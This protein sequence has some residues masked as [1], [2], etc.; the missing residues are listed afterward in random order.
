MRRPV[1][2]NAL[3]SAVRSQGHSHAILIG[4]VEFGK[5]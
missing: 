5:F 2:P 4:S 1:L 3:G